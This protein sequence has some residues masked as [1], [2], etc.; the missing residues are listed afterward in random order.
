MLITKL[1]R[2]LLNKISNQ[3]S[4]Q[5]IRNI[6]WLGGAELINRVFRLG[7]TVVLA[8]TLSPQDYGLAAIVLTTQDITTVF[9]LNSGI[10][11]KIIHADQKD[12]QSLANTA[13]WLNWI[14]CSLL[15]L[16]QCIAA[17]PVALFYKEQKLILPICTIALIYLMVPIFST[18]NAFN[19]RE[20]KLKV[21]AI[22]NA[23]QSMTANIAAILFAWLG[24]GM[25]SLVLPVVLTTPIWIIVNYKYQPWRPSGKFTLH[26][27]QE[28]VKFGKD[29][30]GSEILDK[31]RANLD[32]F[33]IGRFLGV[34]ALGL[35]FFA[36]NAGLGISM[37]VI[38]AMV[39]PLFPHLC[40][41]RQNF[42]QFKNRY[43]SSLRTIAL[44]IIPLVLLQS[45][46]APFY[47][48]IIFS[49]K[50]V[51]AIPILT[52]ICLSAIPRPFA[53]AAAM[54]LQSVDKGWINLCWNMI[55]TCIFATS[56]IIGMQW[57]TIGVATAV[58]ITHAVA[59]PI[60]SIWATKYVFSK[61]IMSITQEGL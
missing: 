56:L 3:L 46:L 47:V 41:A 2:L 53:A 57:G 1:K 42:Q 7:T 44:V 39:W 60:F 35:Y 30:L 37:N 45:S 22:C 15:F 51:A 4:N 27:W 29:I 48:P 21:A 40:A 9:T 55:F 26:R 33:L 31:I 61:Q 20:N 11:N 32:Y 59:M 6:G 36:F 19:N 50:W 49:Q 23:L 12:V 8:R 58:L 54:L 24:L 43:F 18:Q 25:W 13:Y 14:I 10:G 52:I 5:F 38:N 28:I 16:I 17:F 34:E